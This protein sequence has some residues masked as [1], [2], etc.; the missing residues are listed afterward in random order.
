MDFSSILHAATALAHGGARSF[1]AT[2][3]DSVPQYQAPTTA[4]QKVFFTQASRPSQSTPDYSAGWLIP[5]NHLPCHPVFIAHS[6]LC[7]IALLRDTLPPSSLSDHAWAQLV[8]A[9][10]TL[11][12][13]ANLP[14]SAQSPAAGRNATVCSRLSVTAPGRRTLS[15]AASSLSSKRRRLDSATPAPT[16]LEHDRAHSPAPTAASE[17]P[18]P[19]APQHYVVSVSNNNRRAERERTKKQAAAFAKQ[20]YSYGLLEPA[21]SASAD[22]KIAYQNIRPANNAQVAWVIKQPVGKDSDFYQETKSPYSTACNMLANARAVGTPSTW[23]NVAAFLQAWRES[24]SPVPDRSTAVVS[25]QTTQL[26]GSGPRGALQRAY[27]ISCVAEARLATAIIEYRW[28]MAFL[29]REY[30]A[31]IRALDDDRRHA[32]TP[33]I[34][35]L[36]VEMVPNGTKKQ[37]KRF[38]KRLAVANR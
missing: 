27:H 16:A 8:S 1:P 24:G 38:V 18:S 26:R 21:E 36:W 19:A 6:L 29:G 28:A 25:S 31:E 3:D 17:P 14:P 12:T 20:K 22:E 4:Y 13:D 32:R 34:D 15:P 2:H 7:A 37:R 23:Q 33:V 35:R 10:V 30:H 9:A 11:S 5:D